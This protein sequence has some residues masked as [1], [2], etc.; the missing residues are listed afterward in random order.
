MRDSKLSNNLFCVEVKGNEMSN[1]NMIFC[2]QGSYILHLHIY[3]FE[4][5][6]SKGFS[7]LAE[8]TREIKR[9]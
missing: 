2:P 1:K 8:D 3:F 4:D 5:L 9:L 6:F 7:L